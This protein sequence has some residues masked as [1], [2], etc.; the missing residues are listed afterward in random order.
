MHDRLDLGAGEVHSQ[1]FVHAA[2]ERLPGIPVHTLSSRVGAARALGIEAF[3][4]G[5]YSD[6]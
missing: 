4:S 1:A 3:G 6:M 2:T 5:Q